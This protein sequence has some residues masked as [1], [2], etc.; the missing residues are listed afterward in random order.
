M[1]LKEKLLQIK[2]NQKKYPPKSPM[3]KAANYMLNEW[4]G[5]EVTPTGGDYSWDNNLIERLN[6]YVSLSRKKVMLPKTVGDTP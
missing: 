4:D 6:C 1:Q 3:Y 2:G 5:I